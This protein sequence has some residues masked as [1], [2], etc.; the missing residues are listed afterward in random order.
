M[1]ERVI[2][3]GFGGQ[4]MMMLGKMMAGVAMHEGKEVTF[5]PSYGAEV[6]GGTAHCHVII[7]DEPIYSPIVEEADTL[8][9]MNQPSYDKFRPRLRPGGLLLLNTSMAELDDA[10]ECGSSVTCLSAP[11]TEI[12]N[13]LGNVRVANVVMLGVYAQIRGA[14]PAMAL[15]DG[16][17]AGFG[18]RKAHLLEVNRQAFRRGEALAALAAEAAEFSQ[19]SGAGAAASA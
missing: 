19:A 12:A 9:I 17:E 4:G 18:G 6:R 14:L 11:A 8:I 1:T 16:L 2:M 13:D 10:F 15:M 7:S 5:F 3:A